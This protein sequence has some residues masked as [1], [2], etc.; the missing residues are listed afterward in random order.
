V[1]TQTTPQ[2]DTEKLQRRNRELS[3]LN[4]IAD[5]L[6]RELDLSAAL[7]T[8]LEQVA[9]LLNLETGWIW[10]FED[11]ITQTYLA[12]S[13]N[14]PPG[15]RDYP[16]RMTGT[17]YCLD[18]FQAGDM[19]GAANVNVVTC[20]RLKWLVGDTGGLRYHASVPL[21]AHGRK[22]GMMNVASTDWRELSP[23]DLQI[24]YTI[25]D[26]LGIA[27]ERARLFA[28]SAEIGAA[29]ERNRLARE[30]HD[31]L[32]QGLAAIALH[33]ETA[34]ALMET[35][36]EADRARRAVQQALVLSRTNL[37][38]ARRSVLDLRA[39]PLE[40][41]TLV[42]ALRA[43]AIQYA[44]Q[45]GADI[46]FE[47]LGDDRRLPTRIEMG[48]YR[49]AQEALSNIARHAQAKHA[50]LRLTIT[51]QQAEIAIADDGLGFDAEEIPEERFGLIGLNERARLLNGTFEVCSA[52]SEGTS[53]QAVLPL[54]QT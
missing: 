33:L 16:Q 14:L 25:G 1:S 32:A 9:A 30:I 22:V 10:L 49:I 40:G 2:S 8:A 3:I 50:W 42:E 7:Q 35:N 51:P 38:E 29:Q 20:S 18:T 21:Y 39:A 54:E 48:L 11:D 31:T 44:Q 4:T 24:L 27:I 52:P 53:L 46:Q 36:P 13:Q 45:S 5:A 41:R 26:L 15:L 17:C 37:E 12:A 28:R 47:L 6:N 34:D 23:E 43:L 19:S